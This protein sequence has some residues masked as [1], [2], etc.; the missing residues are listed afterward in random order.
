MQNLPA[1]L[2]LDIIQNVDILE[3]ENVCKLDNHW[4]QFCKANEKT[5]IK[6]YLNKYMNKYDHF[7]DFDKN[8]TL[9]T[10]QWKFKLL[11]RDLKESRFYNDEFPNIVLKVLSIYKMS[12]DVNLLDLVKTLMNRNPTQYEYRIITE[13]L[14]MSNVDIKNINRL[15]QRHIYGAS[16]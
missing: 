9:S 12:R 15:V 14:A 16:M 1:E 8:T 11:K 5:I 6:F 13:S 3:L 4:R 10:L 2:K 7:I